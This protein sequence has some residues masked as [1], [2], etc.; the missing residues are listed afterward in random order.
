MI[1]SPDFLSIY[2]YTEREK[3][4]GLNDGQEAESEASRPKIAEKQ[5][6]KLRG[7]P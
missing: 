1:R 2:L 3:E 5:T 7:W 4:A 6:Q